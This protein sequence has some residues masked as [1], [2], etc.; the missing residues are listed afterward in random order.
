[1]KPKLKPGF[2]AVVKPQPAIMLNY[3]KASAPA[4]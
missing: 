4:K 3:S 1:M 2:V